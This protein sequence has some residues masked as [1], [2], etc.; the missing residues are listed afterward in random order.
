MR[1]QVVF[2]HVAPLSRG[3]PHS[4]A[5]LRVACAPCNRRKGNKL[6]AECTWLKK[7]TGILV[8]KKV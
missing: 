1:Y 3:G 6:P 5:N 2:D 4:E 7:S 8:L